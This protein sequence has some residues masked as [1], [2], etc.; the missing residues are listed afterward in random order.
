[1]LLFGNGKLKFAPKKKK[2]KSIL[3]STIESLQ[4]TD[5]SKTLL[6]N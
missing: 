3:T 4:A 1:M 2:K 5:I 6:S